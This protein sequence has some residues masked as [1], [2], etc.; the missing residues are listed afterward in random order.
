[1]TAKP[2]GRNVSRGSGL[3]ISGAALMLGGKAAT[4]FNF[5]IFVSI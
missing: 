2:G 5:Q 1:M 3:E 4:T